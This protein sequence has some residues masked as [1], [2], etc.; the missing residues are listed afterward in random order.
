[1]RKTARL[2]CFSILIGFPFLSQVSAAE[3]VPQMKPLGFQEHNSFLEGVDLPRA[4]PDAPAVESSKEK[5]AT[6]LAP[7]CE[8]PGAIFE[9]VVPFDGKLDGDAA[10]GIA[11]PIE[12]TG[13]QQTG[14]K[15]RFPAPVTL[16]CE[17][18]KVLTEWVREDVLPAA[19][20]Y[21]ESAVS[22]LNSGPG[23]QCRRRNNQP[24]GKLSE[25]ALGTAIDL[26]GFKFD[27]GSQIS[28]EKD[29]GTDTAKGKFL[30][31]IHASACKRFSTVLGPDADPN[32]KSHYHL[33]TGCHGKTCTYLICQ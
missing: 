26:S 9:Q 31:V 1:M 3:P 28:I 33:D 8:I 27:D 20:D 23:Y 16:S 32:H 30:K 25:H 10:C 7:T 4:K 5:F 24:D 22:I 13:F 6:A 29:W 21:F 15:V 2:F 14:S 19:N 11:D 17:F 12:L 18:A